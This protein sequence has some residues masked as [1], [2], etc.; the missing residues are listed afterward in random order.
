MKDI[1]TEAER[2]VPAENLTPRQ[3]SAFLQIPETTLA[4]WRATNRVVLPYFK[5]GSLV[6]YRRPDLDRFIEQ[7]MRN[8]E[9]VST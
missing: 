5:L 2:M 1:A 9:R 4:I 8:T 6:R 7:N 3:A